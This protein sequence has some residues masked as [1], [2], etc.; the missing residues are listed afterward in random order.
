[1]WKGKD[2]W[3]GG[4]GV[5]DRYDWMEARS[6]FSTWNSFAKHYLIQN[7]V[8]DWGYAQQV[9]YLAPYDSM[10]RLDLM[11]ITLDAWR[12]TEHKQIIRQCN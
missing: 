6:R 10:D 4:G 12:V 1:M 7:D 5:A 2:E 11:Q 3:D 9:K 8:V